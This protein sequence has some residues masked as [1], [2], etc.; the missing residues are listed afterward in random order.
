MSDNEHINLPT[1]EFL[2]KLSKKAKQL[3][4]WVDIQLM[5]KTTKATAITSGGL[6]AVKNL[7]GTEVR[8]IVHHLRVILKRPI[9]S[10]GTGY[11]TVTDPEELNDT[12]DQL[13]G[14]INSIGEVRD[15]LIDTR[16]RM[17]LEKDHQRQN[18]ARK[19][20]IGNKVNPNQGGLFK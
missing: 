19:G 11:F 15:A 5:A 4:P 8:G 14:R 20:K 3:L 1:F 17:R 16:R 18:N 6:K 7:V 12:I 9:A 2:P 13:R 10:G